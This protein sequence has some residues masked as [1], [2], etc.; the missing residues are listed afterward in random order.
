MATAKGRFAAALRFDADYVELA[1]IVRGADATKSVKGDG[2]ELA[3]LPANTMA[4]AHVSGA[5]QMIGSAWPQLE[6]QIND[7]AAA[8]DQDDVIA[9]IED[10]LDVTLPDDLKVLLGRSFTVAM[11]DQD[12][13]GDSVTVGAKVVSS[14]AKRADE[15]IDRLVQAS[16]ADSSVLTHKVEGDKVYVAT[17]PDYADDLKSGGKLGDSD[18][19]KLAVG[20]VT[21]SN[22]AV[23][24]DLDKLEKLYLGEVKGN[25]KTFLESLR[26]VG[27][28][29]STTGNGEGTF[30]LRVLG[31]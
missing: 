29:A 16:G 1:G 21:S 17:T 28:N 9:T 15:I 3:N 8:D 22:S 14:D 4:A 11:P 30:T 31:N 19:F 24:V 25:D 7:L 6:K 2:A 18:A 12:L 27:V 5:D 26:A 13:K 20:D 23:F 10:Q